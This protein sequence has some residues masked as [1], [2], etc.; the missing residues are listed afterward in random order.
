MSVFH[1]LCD[2]SEKDKWLSADGWAPLSPCFG[3][4]AVKVWINEPYH[5]RRPI[6]LL[7][8]DFSYEQLLLSLHHGLPHFHSHYMLALKNKTA[9][10]QSKKL[11]RLKDFR[12]AP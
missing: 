8:G 9:E 12:Y 6:V 1:F 3:K 2:F 4:A 7:I 5:E 10:Q 11:E